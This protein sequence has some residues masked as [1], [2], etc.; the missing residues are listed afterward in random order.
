M[1]YRPRCQVHRHRPFC[2]V[3]VNATTS[4][5]RLARKVKRLTNVNWDCKLTEVSFTGSLLDNAQAHPIIVPMSGVSHQATS[6][7]QLV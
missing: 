5:A 4:K 2:A 6:E 7:N 1:I 3:N